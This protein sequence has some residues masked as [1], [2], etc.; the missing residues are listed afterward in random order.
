M[1][2][3]VYAFHIDFVEFCMYRKEKSL[4]RK[5]KNEKEMLLEYIIQHYGLGEYM[6]GIFSK[7][8]NNKK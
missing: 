8:F 4:S 6:S 7:P 1:N 5:R 3:L 2:K